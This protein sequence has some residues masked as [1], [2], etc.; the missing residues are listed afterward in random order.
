M[1]L[2]RAKLEQESMSRLATLSP[3]KKLLLAIE[4]SELALSLNEKTKK[5]ISRLRRFTKSGK[6]KSA[7]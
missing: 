3:A 6:K 5:N 4:L 1:S 2:I 7:T